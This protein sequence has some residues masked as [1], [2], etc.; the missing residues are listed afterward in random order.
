[1]AYHRNFTSGYDTRGITIPY[2][3]G[4]Y[5]NRPDYLNRGLDNGY[6][7]APYPR[8]YYDRPAGYSNVASPTLNWGKW[9]PQAIADPAY[10]YLLYG[11]RSDPLITSRD[12]TQNAYWGAEY[13]DFPKVANRSYTNW[14][15]REFWREGKRG[16]PKGRGEMKNFLSGVAPNFAIRER[17]L[18]T[19]YIIISGAR[20]RMDLK[21]RLV[22]IPMGAILIFLTEP[23]PADGTAAYR[24]YI[25]AVQVRSRSGFY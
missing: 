19:P 24:E 3:E 25:E 22:Q 23:Q 17:E 2:P 9:D 6:E 1:M 11:S 8:R 4:S 10:F 13:A 14:I 16:L 18:P 21:N 7:T 5:V 20:G 15:G 12:G